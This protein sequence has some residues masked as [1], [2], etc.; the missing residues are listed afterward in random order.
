MYVDCRGIIMYY[1][2]LITIGVKINFYK[3]I[4]Y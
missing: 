3:P 1:Y 4:L 2:L